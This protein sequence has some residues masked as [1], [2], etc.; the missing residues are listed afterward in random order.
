M[1]TLPSGSKFLAM[2]VAD[3]GMCK[4]AMHSDP[5]TRVG[6]IPYMSPQLLRGDPVH[7][8]GQAA[9]RAADVYACGVHLYKMLFLRYPFDGTDAAEMSQNIIH[10]N[11]VRPNHAVHAEIEDLLGKMLNKEW[12]ERITIAQIMQHPAYLENLPSEIAVRT[13]CTL[14]AMLLTCV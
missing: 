13:Q 1:A 2:K 11:I 7:S 9:G 4:A 12:Q 6:T 10:G 5:K 14:L 3:F 8:S